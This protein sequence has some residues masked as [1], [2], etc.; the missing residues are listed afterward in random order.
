MSK[1]N[2][3]NA[4][5]Y[6]GSHGG[7]LTTQLIGQYPDFYQAAATRNPVTHLEGLYRLYFRHYKLLK[8]WIF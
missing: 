2:F 5:V 1:Y 7:F 3:K 8:F 6:G 4:V